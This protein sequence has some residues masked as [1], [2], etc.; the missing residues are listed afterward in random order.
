MPNLTDE[1]AEIGGSRPQQLAHDTASISMSAPHLA[2]S[3]LAQAG[4]SSIRSPAFNA[5]GIASPADSAI[6][7]DVIATWS[8]YTQDSTPWSIRREMHPT[9]AAAMHQRWA[10]REM[11]DQSKA[12]QAQ[13]ARSRVS[14]HAAR[15]MR[16][17][18]RPLMV[19]AREF[20]GSVLGDGSGSE[21]DSDQGASKAQPDITVKHTKRSQEAG[22]RLGHRPE[23]VNAHFGHLLDS[24][25]PTQV[26]ASGY[27]RRD[28]FAL[29]MQ[30]KAL[31]ALS[32][33]P[34]GIDKATFKRAIPQLMVEDELFVDRVYAALDAD[35]SG[36]I[37]W[38][39]FITA[40]S[41]LE[42]GSREERAGF[43]FDVYDVDKGGSVD[44][45][46]MSEY[47]LSSL[48]V[49]DDEGEASLGAENA[50]F[51]V[52]RVFDTIAPGEEEIERDV[53]AK[54]VRS[55]PEITD[56]YGMFGRSML[57]FETVRR[58]MGEVKSKPLLERTSTLNFT[59]AKRHL[60]AAQS[61]A[62]RARAQAKQDVAEWKRE[63]Q[64]AEATRKATR[65][66]SPS[67]RSAA[68]SRGHQ[69]E[70]AEAAPAGDGLDISSDDDGQS[71]MSRKLDISSPLSRH[72]SWK[73][74][75]LS[76]TAA[77]QTYAN[78][79]KRD[80]EAKSEERA[81]IIRVRESSSR[82]SR[83]SKSPSG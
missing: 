73:T 81:H 17:R 19:L 67:L 58:M 71:A 21:D 31:C 3:S 51:F 26:S 7:Q 43:M 41:K 79:I 42:N 36:T 69:T 65:S 39:E 22:A 63:K 83:R 9:L 10:R 82:Q 2:R 12:T 15:L 35:G 61:E 34:A 54:Y 37:E 55:H 14:Q 16:E 56:I 38:D 48:R 45:D 62:M 50:S 57:T 40:M 70:S 32:T 27:T 8:Q 76:S 60:S 33:T 77:A 80:L 46:E 72:S 18:E 66:S 1:A 74:L 20:A 30:F 68:N 75:R 6:A 49:N 44:R 24:N 28:L 53:M 78:A 11:P 25:I 4:Q 13:D 47:F 52:D 23:A 59:K 64:L 29:F 5:P